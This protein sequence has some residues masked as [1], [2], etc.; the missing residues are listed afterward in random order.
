VSEWGDSQ[1]CAGT[2]PL[3]AGLCMWVGGEERRPYGAAV[4]GHMGWCWVEFGW[5]VGG[6][7]EAVPCFGNGR[8]LVFTHVLEVAARGLGG[9]DVVGMW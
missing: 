7:L 2:A 3:P 6:L 5:L 1:C 8:V 9:C 4:G